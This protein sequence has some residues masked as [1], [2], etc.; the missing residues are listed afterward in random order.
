M[1]H[2]HLWQKLWLSHLFFPPHFYGRHGNGGSLRNGCEE[3]E[4][5]FAR[6]FPIWSLNYRRESFCFYLFSRSLGDTKIWSDRARK[7]ASNQR[8]W[9][10]MAWSAIIQIG[11]TFMVWPCIWMTQTWRGE[12]FRSRQNLAHSRDGMIWAEQFDC[13]D[14][15]LCWPESRD[16]LTNVCL[17]RIETKSVEPRNEPWLSFVMWALRNHVIIALF[18]FFW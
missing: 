15:Q 14:W 17:C 3:G 2:L 13:F 5:V 4:N 7:K 10:L 8:K 18:G 1:C 9:C 16:G 11:D 6:H 12:I